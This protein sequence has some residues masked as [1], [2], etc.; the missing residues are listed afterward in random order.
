MNK[1]LKL[2]DLE[3]KVY[4]HYDVPV[5]Y[6]YA[7]ESIRKELEEEKAY[8][9][10][11]PVIIKENARNTVFKLT[12]RYIIEIQDIQ[13][14]IEFKRYITPEAPADGNWDKLIDDI[15]AQAYQNAEPQRKKT[16]ASYIV[17]EVYGKLEY[18]IE[19]M[20]GKEDNQKEKFVKKLSTTPR[21]DGI[22]IK[23]IKEMQNYD[24]S[25]KWIEKMTEADKKYFG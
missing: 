11:V 25:Q 15:K 14:E 19:E 4:Y 13:S 16:K 6:E 17:E 3:K 7:K 20:L 1:N 18:S 23:N 22:R 10:E 8:Y 12:G 2:E 21:Y 24:I 5:W 9:W